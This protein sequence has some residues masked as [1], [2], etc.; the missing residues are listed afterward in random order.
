MPQH[1]PRLD[2]G[3]EA[4]AVQLDE[5]DKQIAQ[6]TDQRDR[7]LAALVKATRRIARLVHEC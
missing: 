1:G 3:R 2:G 5:K 4:L 6:L 7:A